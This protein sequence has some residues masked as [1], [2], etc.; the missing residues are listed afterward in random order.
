M[1][2]KKKYEN[3]MDMSDK[4]YMK[5]LKK[6][7]YDVEPTVLDVLTKKQ[8]KHIDKME[9]PIDD[10]RDTSWATISVGEKTKLLMPSVNDYDEI[11]DLGVETN[12]EPALRFYMKPE[13][14]FNYDTEDD[15]EEYISQPAPRYANIPKE[16]DTYVDTGVTSE[17]VADYILET[18]VPSAIYSKAEF[19]EKFEGLKSLPSQLCTFIEFKESVFAY[20]I[21]Y[22]EVFGTFTTAIPCSSTISMSG[23]I[24]NSL[25]LLNEDLPGEIDVDKLY[26]ASEYKQVAQEFYEKYKAASERIVAKVP[27]TK[28]LTLESIRDNIASRLTTF[29]YSRPIIPRVSLDAFGP[30]AGE[31]IEH[32]DNVVPDLE[33][34]DEEVVEAD[35]P[36]EVE[37]EDTHSAAPINIVIDDD[38]DD[39]ENIE[40][41]L[42]DDY[43]DESIPESGDVDGDDLDSE[44]GG[45]VF[46]PVRRNN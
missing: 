20:F 31:V 41:D 19:K 13:A 17:T 33:V 32:I 44:D 3:L 15:D 28:A 11:E 9:D 8:L 22:P 5:Y 2:K 34:E 26:D 46:T 29:M 6:E 12:N 25:V 14:G 21:D 40:L 37:V 43:E 16:P 23:D 36:A 24:V 38:I 39:D 18:A 35:E 30:N 42:G 1:G 7:G 45:F 10:L 27:H 4:E